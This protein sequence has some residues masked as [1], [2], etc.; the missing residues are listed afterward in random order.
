MSM[1]DGAALIEEC[2]RTN[3]ASDWRFTEWFEGAAGAPH[4]MSGQPWN[5][6]LFLLAR[7]GLDQKI[8]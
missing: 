3:A 6:A 4:G 1:T 5:A 8:F 2:A 7:E